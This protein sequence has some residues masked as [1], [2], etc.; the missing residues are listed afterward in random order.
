MLLCSSYHYLTFLCSLKASEAEEEVTRLEKKIRHI[1]AEDAV[2]GE[3]VDLKPI[4]G[5]HF[6]KELKD[7]SCEVCILQE[8]L[9]YFNRN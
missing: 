6:T 1:Q 7:V 4:E 5:L 8:K 3:T 9:K 2:D